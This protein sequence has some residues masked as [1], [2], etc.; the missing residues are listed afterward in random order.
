MRGQGSPAPAAQVDWSH[1]FAIQK[2]SEAR[3]RRVLGLPPLADKPTADLTHARFY[4]LGVARSRAQWEEYSATRPAE[5]ASRDLCAESSAE[6]EGLGA[7]PAPN[8]HIQLARQRE[9][10][11]VAAAA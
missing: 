2:R 5:R 8:L 1:R 4:A 10:A 11:A 7:P 9:L 6:N 3:I